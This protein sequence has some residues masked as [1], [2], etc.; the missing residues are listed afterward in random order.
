MRIAKTI[1]TFLIIVF[2]S[3]CTAEQFPGFQKGD[4]NVYYKVHYKTDDTA[5]PHPLNWV[6]LNLDYRLKDTVLYSSKNLN[7]P[8]KFSMIDPM[9]EGDLYDGLA[10][11]TVGDS[12]TFAIV[13]DS[14]FMQ[15]A[16]FTE[17]PDFVS[18]GD[19][20]FYDVKLLK[21]QNDEQYQEELLQLKEQMRQDELIKLDEYLAANNITIP[22]RPSGLY[23]LP[24]EEGTGRRPDTGEMCRVFL[25]V[26]ILDGDLLYTNFEGTPLD[27][28]YGKNFDTKGFME[29][30]GLTKVGGSAT[31]IVPSPIGVGDRGKETVE[32]FTTIIYKIKLD[33]LRTVEEVR[34]ERAERKKARDAERQRLKDYE[35]QR[36]QKYLND[37]SIDTEP[38]E[39]GL[40]FI[41]TE[42]GNGLS[43]VEGDKVSVKYELFNTNGQMIS[44]SEKDGI[45]PEFI[46]GKN[47]VIMAWE[48]AILLMEYGGKA[49]IIVPSKLAYGSRGQGKSIGAYEP[50][51]YEMELLED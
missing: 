5:R 16:K 10:M 35:V 2:L 21:V 4:N 24:I 32:P 41:E 8:L 46:V 49:R 27:V 30:L 14:F 51:I 20:M 42:K 38:T 19:P 17:L 45:V 15:T 26:Q 34:K 48:E 44:S 40:Y 31:L 11:M 12:M 47:Q 7:K 25:E 50:L 33:A 28:E 3:A 13:A 39:S 18:P 23:Y 6:T 43:P 36:L 9:F 1:G 29:G 22:P 37:N